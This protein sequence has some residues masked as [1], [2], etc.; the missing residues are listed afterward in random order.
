VRRRQAVALGLVLGTVGV[1]G[2]LAQPTGNAPPE[3]FGPRRVSV[4]GIIGRGIEW[5]AY[6]IF[7]GSIVAIALIIDQF[8]TV[9]VSTMVPPAQVRRVRQMIE[10]RQFRE[11]MNA[12]QRSS[13]F[14]AQTMAAALRHAPH[15]YESMRSAAL[16]RS[17]E[18][19]GRMFRRVEYLNI[20]GNLGPLLGLLGTVYGMIKAFGALGAGGGEAASDAGALAEGISLALVNTLLGLILAVIGM[21]FFG[22]CRNRLDAL[23]VQ[24]TVQVLDLLEYFRPRPSA[25]TAPPPPAPVPPAGGAAPV[26]PGPTRRA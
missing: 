13:T 4:W 17:G 22:W 14:F 20:L 5:P 2:A 16:D 8:L 21:G 25:T 24:A 7:A 23:S 6:L 9:R 18:L 26:A 3:D 1:A 10:R 19:S 15:G 11:C 12:V